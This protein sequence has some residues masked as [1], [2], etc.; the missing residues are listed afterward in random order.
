MP[1]NKKLKLLVACAVWSSVPIKKIS[2]G[3]N[4]IPPTPTVPIKVPVNN[5]MHMIFSSKAL[6]NP[7][8]FRRL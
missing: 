2:R 4:N 3:V 7:I 1:V 8:G 6:S 5:P